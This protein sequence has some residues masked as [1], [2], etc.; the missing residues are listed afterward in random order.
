MNTYAKLIVAAA[1][2]LVVALV[3][4]QFL[5]RSGGVGGEPTIAPSPSPSVLARGNFTAKGVGVEL[6]ATGDGDSVTGIMTVGDP[7]E[8]MFAVDL[9]CARTADDG[10]ILIGG[11]T[12]ES[13]ADWATEGDVTAIVLKPGSPVHAVFGF[14]NDAPSADT[15]MGYLDEIVDMHFTTAIGDGALEPIRDGTVELRP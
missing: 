13:N 5:P 6:D 3:G 14:Q 7:S 12:T 9:Q 2:V 1:A 4:Y 10:R 8:P 15:C 11:N